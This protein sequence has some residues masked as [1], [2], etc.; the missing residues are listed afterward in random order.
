MTPRFDWSR[1]QFTGFADRDEAV[2]FARRVEEI[3]AI[4]DA[5]RRPVIELVTEEEETAS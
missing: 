4:E 3:A 1:I 5:K 2:R